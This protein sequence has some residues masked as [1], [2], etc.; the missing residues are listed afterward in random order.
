MIVICKKHGDFF[1]SP[2]NHLRGAE[3]PVCYGTPKKSTAQFINEAIA[4][5]GNKYDYSK[6]EYQG[7]KR[8]VCIIWAQG[9]L[10]VDSSTLTNQNILVQR[11]VCRRKVLPLQHGKET[12]FIRL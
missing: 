12:F 6:V 2:N 10:S 11:I 9:R 8:K 5:H 1:V 3:C 4:K 7:N